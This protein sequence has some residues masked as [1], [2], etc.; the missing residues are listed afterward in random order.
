MTLFD[1]VPLKNS[2]LGKY[3]FIFTENNNLFS[4]IANTEESA[5]LFDWG[6]DLPIWKQE[7]ENNRIV[8]K[9]TG[10]HTIGRKR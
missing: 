8:Y 7:I 1:V 2:L 9:F 6:G 5:R 10:N 4:F 3:R